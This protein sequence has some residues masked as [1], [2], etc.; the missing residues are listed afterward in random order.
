MDKFA[1]TMAHLR[2]SGVALAEHQ[3]EET[4]RPAVEAVHC[5]DYV[6]AILTQTLDSERERRIGFPITQRVARRSLLASGGTWL[7]ATLA[8]EQGYAANTAGGSHHAH[9][10]FGSGFCVLNDV[11]IM[12]RRL[13]TEGRIGR[14]LVIDLDVHQGDGTAAIFD[15]D[16]AVFTLSVHCEANFPVRKAR[17]DLDIGLPMGTGD[18]AYLAVVEAHVPSLIDQVRPDLVAYVAGVD[19]HADDKLGRLALTDAGLM[20]RETLVAQACRARGVP[21][22][23]VMGGGYGD[24]VDAVAA[25]HA[26]SILTLAAAFGLIP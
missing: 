16:P 24:D 18:D 20:A 25:R 19:V 13:L 6:A 23:S 15:G 4:P 26:R 17:S 9:R 8:L 11:A 14:L 12:A 22:V 1:R 5:P 7:A 10:A 2:S 21:L 3:P